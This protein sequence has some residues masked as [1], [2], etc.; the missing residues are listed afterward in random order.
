MNNILKLTALTAVLGSFVMPITVNAQRGRDYQINR[1]DKSRDEWKSI[2]TIS[3]AAGLLGLLNHDNTLA[4]AGAA[5][6]LYSMSRYN[7]DTRSRDRMARARAEYFSRDHFY[8]DGVRY[9]RREVDR[10]GQR[11]YQFYRAPRSQQ[12]WDDYRRGH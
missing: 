6:A 8:R 2:A 9:N 4:F 1:R 12:D 10:H 11:Y 3:G 5:G 7:D